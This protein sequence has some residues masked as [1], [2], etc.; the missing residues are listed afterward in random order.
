MSYCVIYSTSF[1][2]CLC[3]NKVLNLVVHH[4]SL[5][6][7]W[8]IPDD[9]YNNILVALSKHFNIFEAVIRIHVKSYKKY[10]SYYKNRPHTSTDYKIAGAL[11]AC[12][13]I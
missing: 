4:Q 13:Y 2:L 3:P 9:A 8:T 12:L 5:Q 7:S 11:T 10:T 1:N 6:K